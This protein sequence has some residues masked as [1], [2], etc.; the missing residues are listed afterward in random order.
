M[1][2]IRNRNGRWHVQVRRSGSKSVEYSHSCALGRSLS[3]I[4]FLSDNVIKAN[5]NRYITRF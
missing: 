3:N 4:V 1:A 2:T 5:K